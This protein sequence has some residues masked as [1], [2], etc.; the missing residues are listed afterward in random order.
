M[1]LKSEEDVKKALDIESWRN[2][3]KD[4]LLAFVAEMPH[5]DREVAL[6]VIDQFPNFKSLAGETMA[7]FDERFDSAQKFNW[8]SQKKVHQAFQSYR[9]SLDRELERP[10]LSSE[11]RFRI[12]EM[13]R[14]TADRESAKDSENKTFTLKLVSVAAAVGVTVVGAAVAALGGKVGI[15][16]NDGRA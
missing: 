3:S 8:K 7:S 13:I 9:R 4:K 16:G 2:L 5:M 14:E 15:G 12:L 6:K 10:Y 1:I 11:D